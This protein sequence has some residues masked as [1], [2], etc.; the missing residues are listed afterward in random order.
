[1]PSH[2]RYLK[3]REKMREASRRYYRK[4]REKERERGRKWREENLDLARQ[5]DRESQ[6]RRRAQD[7]ERGRA[8][9][10]KCRENETPE[11]REKRLAYIRAWHKAHREKIREYCRKWRAEHPGQKTKWRQKHPDTARAA[12]LREYEQ[13]R[14][15][16]YEN[17][18]EARAYF[19]AQVRNRKA[20]LK[21]TPGHHTVADVEA[22]YK[23][24]KGKCAACKKPFPTTGKTRYTVDHIVPLTP[25]KGGKPGSNGPENLQ[26]LCKPCNSSKYNKDHDEWIKSR[27]SGH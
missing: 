9:Q 21:P 26:L 20:R 3:N 12:R 18:E 19:A 16:Y 27:R 4:N 13:K 23:A 2:E 17:L 22:L 11:R 5:I 14:E 7:P 1:M 6:K 8:I 15:W 25:R 10:R 24:Q